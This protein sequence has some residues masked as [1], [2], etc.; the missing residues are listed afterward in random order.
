MD[1]LW[2]GTPIWL[3][4]AGGGI[5]ACYFYKPQS[6][7]YGLIFAWI[8][9]GFIAI[10]YPGLFQRK[11]AMALAVPVGIAAAWGLIA[12][13]GMKPA[14]IWGIAV[15]LCATNVLWLTREMAMATKN[16]SNTTMQH[17]F[18]PREITEFL[19]YIQRSSAPKDAVIAMPG[20]AVPDDFENPREYAIAIPDLNPVL[21]GWGGVK[22][23]VGHWSETPDYLAKRKR[24]MNDL[25]SPNATQESAYLLMQ[26][27]GANYIVAPISEIAAQAG[28]PKRDFYTG[29]GEV[30]Y[31]GD[32]FILV[33]YRP[34]P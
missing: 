32:E 22:T 2:I 33:R 31:E 17:V 19:K 28:V 21:S 1:T 25:F 13:P 14:T 8:V 20:I 18:W 24:V 15:V 3:A 10:Y 5:A 16:I 23:Y 6:P 34:S 12:L 29:L 27:A 11:L 9:M 26:D 7:V 4:L 30:V